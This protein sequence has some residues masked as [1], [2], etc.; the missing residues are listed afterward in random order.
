MILIAGF[1]TTANMIALGV[2]TLIQHPDQ[3]DR[4][5]KDPSLVPA[6]VEELL[7][8]LTITHWGR[9]RTATEDVVLDGHLIRA[10]EGVIVAQNAANRDPQEFDD[11]DSFDIERGAR[12]HLA[13]GHGVHQ[14]LG[15]SFARLEMVAAYTTILTRFPTME[16]AVPAEELRYKEQSAV[17]GLVSMP[18]TW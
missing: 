6:A 18:V 4:L 7:R 15:A 17:Y 3:R 13:F 1:D 9:H 14:C 16:L 8:Y 10:G 11:P 12:R 2:L 5:A